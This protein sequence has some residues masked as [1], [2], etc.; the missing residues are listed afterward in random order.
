MSSD[1]CPVEPPD[2][3]G[4]T[5]VT[6]SMIQPIDISPLVAMGDIP[7]ADDLQDGGAAVDDDQIAAVARSL[8]TA[9]RDHGFF[10][11]TGHGLDPALRADLESVSHE[12]FALEPD[13]KSRISMARGGRAW[14]GWFPPGDELTS[15][16]PDAKEGIYFGADLSADDPRVVTGTPLHGPNL[17][18]DRPGRMREVVTEWMSEMDRVARSVLR[19]LAIGLGLRAGWFDQNLTADPVVLFRIF[20]Y[21][22][23]GDVLPDDNAPAGG[24]P[25]VGGSGPAGATETS[26]EPMTWGVGEHTDYGLL[27]LLAQDDV[28]GLEVQVDGTWQPVTPIPDAL[29]CNIGDMLDRMT[30][31]RYRSTVHRVRPPVERSR[32]SF[33]FFFDPGWNVEVEPIPLT[34]QHTDGSRPRRWDGTDL[35]QLSGTYGEYLMG[36]VSRVFPELAQRSELRERS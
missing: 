21:P 7:S 6:E 10:I 22:P 27:T 28:G 33:P 17:W 16:R 20:H 36:K 9:C 30:G 13:E 5:G 26:G 24:E 12:F 32:L 11:V 19:G 3:P 18:P 1:G 14:R 2:D 8:D 25:E 29:V 31:G 34:G 4:T 23:V 15:G 35:A